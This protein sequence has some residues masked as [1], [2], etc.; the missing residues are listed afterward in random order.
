MPDIVR[1]FAQVDRELGGVRG[2]VNNAASNGGRSLLKDL[3]RA[4]LERA[5]HTNVFGSF[6]CAREAARRMSVREGGRGGSIVNV[7]S[8]ASRLGSPGEWVHYAASKAAIEAMTLGLSKELGWVPYLEPHWALL[9]TIALIGGAML[10]SL[11][12]TRDETLSRKG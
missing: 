10:Y 4:H 9:M 8:G 7:S 6:L 3:T 12:R 2:L 11:Y 5:F 1:A